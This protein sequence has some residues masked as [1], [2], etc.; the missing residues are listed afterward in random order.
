MEII[1]GFALAAIALVGLF[2]WLGRW[3]GSAHRRTDRKRITERV[4]EISPPPSQPAAEERP[5][6]SR[7]R[8]W[9][10][11]SVTLMVTGMLLMLILIVDQPTS[12]GLV[13]EATAT[14]G[15][16]AGELMTAI[17][18]TEPSMPSDAP[19]APAESHPAPA[20]DPVKP[21]EVTPTPE[22]TPAPAT[23]TPEPSPTQ[24]SRPSIPSSDRLAVLT[25]CANESDCFVY[26][27]RRGD[28]LVSIANWFGIPLA[29]VLTMNP[30][31][32]DPGTVHAG[33]RI[34]IPTPR[35]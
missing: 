11:T 23:P 33:D 28:N 1:G 15:A 26:V 19:P 12:S 6:Q 25:P 18:K 5:S 14:P 24:S 17:P 31:I 30:G 10:D 27:V 21:P 13:L 34:T 3:R 2:A 16:S 35:R 8:L 4:A 9:R 32:Q 29:T 22:P 7:R 20:L